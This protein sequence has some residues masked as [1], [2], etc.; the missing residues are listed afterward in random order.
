MRISEKSKRKQEDGKGDMILLQERING[1][2]NMRNGGGLTEKMGRR[3]LCKNL[4]DEWSRMV[5]LFSVMSISKIH[6]T[7]LLLKKTI[8]DN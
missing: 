2:T 7:I 8:E 5:L 3:N 6:R 1:N 4:G